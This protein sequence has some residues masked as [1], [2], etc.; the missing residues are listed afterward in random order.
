MQ[1]VVMVL[2]GMV[3]ELRSQ[4]GKISL[5]WQ[6]LNKV[7]N[8]HSQGDEKGTIYL[9]FPCVILRCQRWRLLCIT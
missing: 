2:F 8:K 1:P 9:N 6:R 4:T 5:D 3:L 7:Q